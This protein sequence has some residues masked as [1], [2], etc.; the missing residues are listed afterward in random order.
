MALKRASLP[1]EATA[2]LVEAGRRRGAPE[3]LDTALVLPLVSTEMNRW[4]AGGLP[5]VAPEGFWKCL[6]I[7][8]AA[9]AVCGIVCGV[10]AGVLCHEG[11]AR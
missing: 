2:P 7:E 4:P 10:V 8:I 3:Y 1:E 5:P 11:S 6:L 9:D